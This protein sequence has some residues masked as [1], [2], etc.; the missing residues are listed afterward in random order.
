MTGP[1]ISMSS[2]MK[3]SWIDILK[4]MVRIQ[5]ADSAASVMR[6]A[7]KIFLVVFLTTRVCK[8]FP[9]EQS[10]CRAKAS[11]LIAAYTV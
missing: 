6:C 4:A 8:G 9:R 1:L 2:T 11:V 3:A 7:S 10:V 5:R